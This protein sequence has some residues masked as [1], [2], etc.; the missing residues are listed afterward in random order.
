MMSA[1]SRSSSPGAPTTSVTEVEPTCPRSG[2]SGTARI[3]WC[4]VSSDPRVA[5]ARIRCLNPL[6]ELRA[7]GYPVELFDPRRSADYSL[8]VFSKRYDERARA[9]AQRL[10]SRG[11]RVVL[12]LCD[13]HFYNPADDPA[14][15]R[16]ATALRAMVRLSDA[17][18]VSTTALAEVVRAE[19]PDAP[20]ITVIGDAVETEIQH[21]RGGLL[22][23]LVHRHRLARLRRALRATAPRGGR[24]VWFGVA[25]GARG[26]YGMRDLRRCRPAIEE[27]AGEFPL[28]LTVISNSYP[29]FREHVADWRVPTRYLEWHPKTFLASLRE[30]DIAV[31]PVTPSPFTC[32]KT[33]N[34]LATALGAGLAVVADEIPSYRDFAGCCQLGAWDAG[35]RRY[36]TDPSARAADV[37]SGRRLLERE[38]SPARVGD[39]WQH[40][41]DRTLRA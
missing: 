10:R 15:A 18:V 25:G 19:I 35:L 9:E 12:D 3:G 20:E 4:P 37:E 8:V 16:A 41:F 33:N 13:N 24:L 11:V 1:D 6:R 14:L 34:R 23:G 27:L 22:G 5:S 26:D 40:F 17:V 38:W 32:C 21:G 2:P 30:H 39:Q 28:S 31:V 7:R 29:L 36:L